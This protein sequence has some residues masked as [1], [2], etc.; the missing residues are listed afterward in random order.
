LSIAL[1][2][3]Q[4]SGVLERPDVHESAGGILNAVGAALTALLGGQG[5]PAGLI[6]LG[7]GLIGIRDK[8]QREADL[9][10]ARY[11]AEIERDGSFD[12]EWIGNP[13]PDDLRAE[14]AYNPNENLPEGES[15]FPEGVV[16]PYGP[17]GSR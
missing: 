5:T 17:E 12:E 7:V 14:K 10:D 1:G 6:V 3:I 4:A 8:L 2:I 13:H 11:W 16:D 9:G 15:D